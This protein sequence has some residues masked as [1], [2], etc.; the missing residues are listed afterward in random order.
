M[1]KIVLALGFVAVA[2][3]ALAQTPGAIVMP[4][5]VPAIV[6]TAQPPAPTNPQ[7]EPPKN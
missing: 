2:A 7:A 1:K 6:N 3:P 5:A 4:V